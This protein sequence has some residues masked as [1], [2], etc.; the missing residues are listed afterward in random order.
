MK[1]LFI[2]SVVAVCGSCFAIL[3]PPLSSNLP[4]STTNAQTTL[5]INT[6]ITLSQSNKFLTLEMFGGGPGLTNDNAM[7]AA[8]LAQLLTGRPINIT[9][10]ILPYYMTNTFWITNRGTVIKSLGGGWNLSGLS[11]TVP[12]ARF[13][14]LSG[15]GGAVTDGFRF[16]EMGQGFGQNDDSL[17]AN[18][19]IIMDNTASVAIHFTSTNGTSD[20]IQL[21]NMTVQALHGYGIWDEWGVSGSHFNNI[22]FLNCGRGY[23]SSASA[24]ISQGLYL[25]CNVENCDQGIRLEHGQGLNINIIHE[26][27]N[28]CTNIMEFGNTQGLNLWAGHLEWRDGGPAEFR[29]IGTGSNKN[30]HFSGIT[31]GGNSGA[32]WLLDMADS[33]VQSSDIHFDDFGMGNTFSNIAGAVVRARINSYG[34][35]SLFSD[36]PFIASFYSANTL[37]VSN[38]FITHGGISANSSDIGWPY[39]DFFTTVP[40]TVPTWLIKFP[41]NQTA[42]GIA[43]ADILEFWKRTHSAQVSSLSVDS[44]LFLGGSGAGGNVRTLRGGM[45]FANGG[46]TSF[47]SFLDNSSMPNE[48]FTGTRTNNMMG[49]TT[50]ALPT[51]SSQV[52]TAMGIF[53]EQLGANTLRY[54]SKTN[55][56]TGN[57]VVLQ[58]YSSATYGGKP[59]AVTV[60]ASVFTFVNNTTVNLECYFS[61]TAVAYS[62]SKNGAAVYPSLVG[63]DYLILQPTNSLAITYSVT[64]PTFYTNSW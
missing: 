2:I 37:T 60:G 24:G 34:S 64:P 33:A 45:G 59:N 46:T 55:D 8:K 35:Q 41:T 28:N 10:S 40:L 31:E 58:A 16:D 12:P 7:A 42:T 27:G 32:C 30:I 23:Y 21:E 61:S 50:D 1:K 44:P 63:D 14:F 15:G 51:S 11:S 39:W 29:T 49:F 26:A 56:A 17:L 47:G 13:E 25:S 57:T 38:L 18:F 36:T 4:G 6:A 19:A 54:S 62:I 52:T 3:N 9:C 22:Q 20:G 43:I 53:W 48:W 5:Q